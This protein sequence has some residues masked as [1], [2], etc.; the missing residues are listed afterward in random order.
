MAND[1]GTKPVAL[2]VTEADGPRDVTPGDPLMINETKVTFPWVRIMGGD[3]F[4]KVQTEVTF[5]KLEM[6]DGN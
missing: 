4:A 1:N 6:V 3:V 5:T 2:T